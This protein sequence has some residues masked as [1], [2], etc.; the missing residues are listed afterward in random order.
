MKPDAKKVLPPPLEETEPTAQRRAVPV[1][2][3]ISFAV[4]VYGGALYFDARGGGFNAQVYEPYRSFEEV[5]TLQPKTAEGEVFAKGRRVFQVY[6]MVCHQAS[7]LGTPGQFPPLAGSEWAL[8]Q[9]PNRIIRLV[10]NGGQGPMEIKGQTYA[11][12]AMPPWKDLL[13]DEDIAAALTY[14]RQ[15]KDWGNSAPEVKPEQIKAIRDKI[16]DRS[17]P[18]SAEELKG[19]P[20]ND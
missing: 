20:E 8:A 13:K 9:S 11:A 6:C 17:D 18:F 7:G 3:I 5:A 12:A 15:N 1:S 19:I 2:L 10:L 4:L 16:K 14:V